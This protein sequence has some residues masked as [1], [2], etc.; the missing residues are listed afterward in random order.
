[1]KEVKPSHREV[2][3]LGLML[4]PLPFLPDFDVDLG[5]DKIVANDPT[6]IYVILAFALPL[7]VSCFIKKRA[8]RDVVR[9][10]Y[11]VLLSILMVAAYMFETSD[12]KRSIYDWGQQY[13]WVMVWFLAEYGWFILFAVLSLKSMFFA[14]PNHET[15]SGIG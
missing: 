3:Y 7:L 5:P 10:L 1:M 2:L 9:L 15:D 14:Q 4:I 6:A 13:P 12:L 11:V 8:T